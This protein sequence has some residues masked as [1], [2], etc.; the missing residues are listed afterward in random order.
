[1]LGLRQYLKRLTPE[2][3]GRLLQN[4]P[5]YFFNYAPY[6]LALGIINPYTRNFGRRK[7]GQCP[8]LVTRITGP[9]TPEE[10]GHLMADV[11]D[12]MDFRSRQMQIE[13]WIPIHIQVT[14]KK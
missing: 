13:K 10:W 5:D 1:M 8:Y 2:N 7:I 12:M 14:R 9:R 11:A 6:A 4:D 3:I